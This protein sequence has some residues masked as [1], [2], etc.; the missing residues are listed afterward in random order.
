[1][2]RQVSVIGLSYLTPHLNIRYRLLRVENITSFCE[3]TFFDYIASIERNL[4]KAA[5]MQSL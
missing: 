1:M 5:G 2:Q 3:L 4:F